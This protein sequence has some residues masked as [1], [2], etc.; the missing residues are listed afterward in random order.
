V[1]VVLAAAPLADDD[2]EPDIDDID[3]PVDEPDVPD[4]TLPSVA[5]D[6]PE[7]A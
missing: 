5:D 6:E 2:A 1:V 3:A 4:V 7:T